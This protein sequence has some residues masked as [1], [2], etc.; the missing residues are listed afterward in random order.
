MTGVAG[1]A[2]GKARMAG[3]AG[4]AEVA[5]VEGQAAASLLRLA[6]ASMS[7]VDRSF[8]RSATGIESFPAGSMLVGTASYEKRN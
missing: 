5:G 7:I 8:G 2:C 3:I 4:V 6:K 1:V